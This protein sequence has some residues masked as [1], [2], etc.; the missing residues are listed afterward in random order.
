MLTYKTYH[1]N[2]Y[3]TYNVIMVQSHTRR[4]VVLKQGS[5]IVTATVLKSLAA[6]GILTTALVAPNSLIL[7]DKYMKSVDKRN[8]RKTLAY[9]KYRKLV[10][11]KEKDGKLHYKLTDVGVKRYKKLQLEELAISIPKKWD[12]KWRFVMFDI[13]VGRREQRDELLNRLKQLNFTM[14]QKSV[15]VH[16]FNCEEQVGV[17]LDALALDKYV[18]FMVVERG[19]FTEQLTSHFKKHKLLI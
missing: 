17:I 3:M 8:A 9:L 15:W 14:L 12:H 1:K 2:R 18:S 5:R 13:P 4:R 11:V 10:Q 16:P 6:A 19:N 7:V